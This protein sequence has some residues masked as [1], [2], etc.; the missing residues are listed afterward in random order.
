MNKLSV[1]Q[2]CRILAM[3]CE[4]SF[5]RSVSR[6]ADVSINTVSKLLVEA[7]RFCACFHDAKIRSVKSKRVQIDEIWCFTAAKQKNVAS[8][9]AP[10]EGAGDTW[11]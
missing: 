5:I 9:K 8:M 1:A 11:T 4:E 6:L 7:G 3:L 10:V 2:C